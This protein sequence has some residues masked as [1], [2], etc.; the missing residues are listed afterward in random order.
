MVITVMVLVVAF[1]AVRAR[2]GRGPVAAAVVTLVVPLGC[3]VPATGW[4]RSLLINL[5]K[6]NRDKKYLNGSKL[7]IALVFL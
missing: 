1:D 7:Q 3:G 2:L 6:L 5:K 4:G